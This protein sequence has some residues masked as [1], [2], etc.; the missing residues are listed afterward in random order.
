MRESPANGSILFIDEA[1][2]LKCH[3]Q[4]LQSNLGIAIISLYSQN[5]FDGFVPGT[6][7]VGEY[8]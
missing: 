2:M 8:L 7:S 1:S 6:Y 4:H 3:P 5:V